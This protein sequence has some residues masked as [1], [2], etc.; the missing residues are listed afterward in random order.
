MSSENPMTPEATTPEPTPTP[1]SEPK[2]ILELFGDHEPPNSIQQAF[3][4]YNR[5]A[6]QSGFTIA[7]TLSDDRKRHLK[8]K[9]KSC[10]GLLGWIEALERAS[11]SSFCRG[12]GNTGWVLNFDALFQNR[13]WNGLVEGKYDD[14][15][16]IG[17]PNV[18]PLNLDEKRRA[19]EFDRG[20]ELAKSKGREA[21]REFLALYNQRS[22]AE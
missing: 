22:A 6:K 8:A 9:L 21:E 15:E 19:E 1:P 12:G 18:I 5:I 17:A 14:R 13:T 11:R 20:W 10:G 16:G 4:A 3:D 2:P 7:K